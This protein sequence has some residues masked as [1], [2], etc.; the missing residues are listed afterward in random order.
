MS[1][2]SLRTIA[3][4][5]AP[6]VVDLQQATIATQVELRVQ[7]EL[8]VQREDAAKQPFTYRDRRGMKE[9]DL[10]PLLKLS[11]NKNFARFAI[12]TNL[13]VSSYINPH[14][15]AGGKSS[16]ETSN[17][18]AYNKMNGLANTVLTNIVDLEKVLKAGFTCAYIF[19]RKSSGGKNTKVIISR[20]DLSDFLS[21]GI[22]RSTIAKLNPDLFEQIEDFLGTCATRGGGNGTQ[23][24]QIIRTL[25]ATGCAIDVQRET[26]DLEIDL[27]NPIVKQ[28]A[29]ALKIAA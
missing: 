8:G 12:A 5:I 4:E 10:Q 2:K 17:L 11:N 15:K 9:A 23:A 24:S 19:A 20:A 6:E 13:D 25:V 3:L 28:L 7:Y 22:A 21:S 14:L 18:K 29:Q 16:S 27:S 26:K 1:S